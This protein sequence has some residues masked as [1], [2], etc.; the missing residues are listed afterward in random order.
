MIGDM[1]SDIA[2]GKAAGCKTCL[3]DQENSLIRIAVRELYGESKVAIQVPA[4][5]M[6]KKFGFVYQK[7][8]F[9]VGEVLKETEKAVFFEP[10]PEQDYTS[11]W[12]PKKVVSIF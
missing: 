10:E 8:L 3:V 1:D 5:Y 6:T 2:A 12:Y 9:M 11:S 7:D 4:W